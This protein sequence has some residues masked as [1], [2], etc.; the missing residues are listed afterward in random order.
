MNNVAQFQLAAVLYLCDDTNRAKFEKQ[1]MPSYRF[2]VNKVQNMVG[3]NS[4]ENGTHGEICV[5]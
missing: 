1:C 5:A 2:C 3:P 4:Y